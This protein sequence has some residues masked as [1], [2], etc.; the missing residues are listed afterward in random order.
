MFFYEPFT[1]SSKGEPAAS[2]S[3]AVVSSVHQTEGAFRV[4]TWKRVVTQELTDDFDTFTREFPDTHHA[5]NGLAEVA[6]REIWRHGSGTVC[7]T[8]QDTHRA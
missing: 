5:A 8:S 3:Y 7:M 4:K 6:L 2:V 1:V